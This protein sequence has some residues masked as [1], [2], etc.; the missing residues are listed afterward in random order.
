[1]EFVASALVVALE[2]RG[3]YWGDCL[4]EVLVSAEA[5]FAAVVVRRKV[6]GESE[7]ARG[8]VEVRE[9]VAALGPIPG[10]RF[11]WRMDPGDADSQGAEAGIEGTPLVVPHGAVEK[12]ARVAWAQE[13]G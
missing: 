1:V 13:G 12:L 3:L 11:G 7:V 8:S 6:V 4:D 9:G 5:Q 2:Q 10:S